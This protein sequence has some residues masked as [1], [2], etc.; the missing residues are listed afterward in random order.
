MRPA[1]HG[2]P[3]VPHAEDTMAIITGFAGNNPLLQG[4][5]EQDFIYGNVRGTVTGVAGNDRIFGLAGD[6]RIAGDG[7][8]IAAGGNPNIVVQ[9]VKSWDEAVRQV[10]DSRMLGGVHY[11]FSNDAGEEI[12]RRVAR[13]TVSSI[14]RPLRAAARKR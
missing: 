13:L 3:P 1:A 10:S 5:A 14:L 11:R 9:S 12:G 2:A 4:T 6:D 7:I 8:T